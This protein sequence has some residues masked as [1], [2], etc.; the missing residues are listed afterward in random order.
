M[1]CANRCQSSRELSLIM[2]Q[3]YRHAVTASSAVCMSSELKTPPPLI[4]KLCGANNEG[5]LCGRIE[6]RGD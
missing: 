4:M 1:S 3:I 6:V 2:G 5:V